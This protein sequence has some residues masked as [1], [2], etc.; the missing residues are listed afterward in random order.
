MNPNYGY[1]LYQAE[2]TQPRAEILAGDARRGRWAAEP[3]AGAGARRAR[4]GVARSWS[5]S[6]AGRLAPRDHTPTDPRR[7]RMRFMLL[8]YVDETAEMGAEERREDRALLTSWLEDTIAR[9]VIL[10]GNYLQPSR[11]AATVRARDGE[12]LVADGPFAETKEQIAGFDIIEC[13]D[14]RE[15]V[16]VAGTHPT[17]RHGTIEIRPFPPE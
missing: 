9:G 5:S 17:T 4:A 10:Q 2:R 15:A 7:D 13:A 11:N 12:L 1:Q 8:H 6:R 14:L 16:E 3:G